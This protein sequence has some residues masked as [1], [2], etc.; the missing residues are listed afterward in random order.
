[1]R[2][3]VFLM[4]LLSAC[5]REFSNI[6]D[7]EIPFEAPSNL[8]LAVVSNY[9]IKLTWN[10]NSD[11]EEGFA[12]ERDDG[13]GQYEIISTVQA[14]DTVYKHQISPE[15]EGKLFSY[16]VRA[17]FSTRNSAYS[18]VES[19]YLLFSPVN[20]AVRLFPDV[21]KAILSWDDSS[22]IEDGFVIERMDD[23]VYNFLGTVDA[24]V[25]EFAID[26][27]Q[28]DSTIQSRKCYRVRSRKN[29]FNSAP[30]DTLEIRNWISGGTGNLLWSGE[31][32]SDITSLALD[33]E[34]L[35]LGSGD[36]SG[37]LKVW[38]FSSGE[39]LW[40]AQVSPEIDTLFFGVDN[41]MIFSL[42]SDSL[43]SAW[44]SAS[45]TALWSGTTTDKLFSIQTG[46][47]P[48]VA[49][50]PQSKQVKVTSL[51]TGIT[52]WDSTFNTNVSGIQ[53][54]PGGSVITV[55]LD[56]DIASVNMSDN[57]VLWSIST[58]ESISDIY[59]TK[60]D[61]TIIVIGNYGMIKGISAEDGSLI[62]QD[63]YARHYKDNIEIPLLLSPDNNKVATIYSDSLKVWNI[64]TGNL[65][66]G[67]QREHFYSAVYSLDCATLFLAY[68]GGIDAIDALVGS[69]TWSKE[70]TVSGLVLS[71]DGSTLV[72]WPALQVIEASNG[73]EI[74]SSSNVKS[75]CIPLINS[76]ASKI[77]RIEW[78]DEV[79]VYS[80]KWS[81]YTL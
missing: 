59:L 4:L 1:M 17:F 7:A 43:L 50:C 19:H 47:E 37:I 71:R 67:I 11:F 49:I 57:R 21:S 61:S 9:E 23:T 20:P 24:N 36:E 38:K 81:A 74:W 53:L 46:A 42:C 45:G 64:A 40:T 60:D 66:L 52:F 55:S 26:L 31:H 30:S 75:S 76:D 35:Y 44:S 68:Y 28:F 34:E 73:S 14:G 2:N 79:M 32:S 51:L 6:Y 27:A 70:F 63:T 16:R 65:N 10:D 78:E 56:R 33:S 48:R 41:S 22:G 15:D 12:I 5:S 72:A 13:S 77:C 25:T 62:W 69:T 54:S 58:N 18:N 80:L 3:F 29:E 8:A 39:Q